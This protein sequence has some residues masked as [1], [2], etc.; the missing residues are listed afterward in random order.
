MFQGIGFGAVLAVPR[1]ISDKDNTAWCC[2]STLYQGPW[3]AFA[4][5]N[6]QPAYELV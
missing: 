2:C 5:V 4:L 6:R 1:L 3:D